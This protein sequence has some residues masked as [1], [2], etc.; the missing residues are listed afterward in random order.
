M[1]LEDALKNEREFF[2]VINS[3]REKSPLLPLEFDFD[4]DD[5]TDF[6]RTVGKVMRQKFIDC[7]ETELTKIKNAKV[8]DICCGPGWLS[9]FSALRGNEV[10]GYDFSEKAIAIAK[11]MSEKKAEL[12]KSKKGSLKYT[13][14]DVNKIEAL[15]HANSIDVAIGW[16]AFHHIDNIEDY[17]N[18]VYKSLRTGG[19][20]V[21]TDDIGS[22]K[23]NRIITWFLKFLLPIKNLSYKEKFK[24]LLIYIPKIFKSEHE[25]HTPMEEYVGKHGD[26]V[27]KIENFIESN[28]EVIMNE[29]HSAFLHYFV[30]DLDGTLRQKKCIFKILYNLDK[31]LINLKVCKGNLR[32]IIAKK[33]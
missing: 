8:I 2:N 30:Y 26:A 24:N 3:N 21:S 14:L 20:I 1:N 10:E 27:Q 18:K 31:L 16:S 4:H 29:R 33:K 15:N 22:K 32:F 12:M 23:I 28:F 9:L 25:M 5:P 19:L 6:N 17:L 7:Y 11:N 13:Q